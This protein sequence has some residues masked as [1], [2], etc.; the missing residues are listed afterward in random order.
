FISRIALHE[1]TWQKYY[2][3]NNERANK[4]LSLAIEAA[5]MVMASGRYDIVT[6]YRSLF[7]SLDLKGNRDVLLYRHYDAAVNIKHAIASN[8]NLTES[9]LFGPSTDLIKSYIASDGQVWQNS[10]I[11]GAS[12]FE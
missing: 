12:N 6:D 11:A 3:N 7:T 9:L 8:S 5:D 4:F 2:Y 1:G 10:E